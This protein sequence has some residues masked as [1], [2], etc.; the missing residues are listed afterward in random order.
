MLP[1]IKGSVSDLASSFKVVQVNTQDTSGGT[2]GG[3]L[4]FDFKDGAWSFGRDGD[5]V[6]GD[7][8][9]IN[10][11]TFAHGWKLWANGTFTSVLVNI[12]D[13][14]PPCPP[15]V[16]DKHASAA[17][18]FAGAFWDQGKPGEQ[19]VFETNSYGG[20]KAVNVLIEAVKAKVQ[21][22]ASFLFP[23]V[24]LGSE[25]YKNQKHGSLIHNPTFEIVDWANESGAAE[26]S[27]GIAEADAEDDTPIAVEAP[28]APAR[29]RRVA[30]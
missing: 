13:A 14:E 12:T 2:L 1:T 4:K 16:G 10:I 19:L 11:R 22:S 28:A 24:K 9:A 27:I 8:V 7:N 25:S 15:P 17:R 5:D 26:S 20:R 18:A 3:Y 29:R 6:T 21:S 23:V 30:G